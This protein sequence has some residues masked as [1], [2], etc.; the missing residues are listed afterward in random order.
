[1]KKLFLI[2]AFIS[3]STSLFGQN[4]NVYIKISDTDTYKLAQNEN[5]INMN[6]DE[7]FHLFIK[8][9]SVYYPINSIEI[10]VLMVGDKTTDYKTAK[11][12][13]AEKKYDITDGILL[14]N[15][16]NHLKRV[17]IIVPKKVKCGDKVVVI[18]NIHKRSFRILVSN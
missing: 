12:Q 5:I 4:K 9:N 13:V 18:G 2:I 14:R 3:I 6:I 8:Y 16:S 11:R 10:N 17:D 7:S 15:I 1:M